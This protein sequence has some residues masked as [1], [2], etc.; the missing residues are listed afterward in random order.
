MN[1]HELIDTII[2]YH[3]EQQLEITCITL[4]FAYYKALE[5]V[6][7]EGKLVVNNVV[8]PT[9]VG[10]YRGINIAYCGLVPFKITINAKTK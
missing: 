3:E 9:K 6:L 8:Y 5:K 7:G 10:T 1:I 2:D 4:G